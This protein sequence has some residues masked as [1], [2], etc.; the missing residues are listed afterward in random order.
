MAKRRCRYCGRWFIADPRVGDR[1]KACSRQC[2][3]LRKKENNH[4]F[5]KNNPGYWH[6]RYE[7]VKQWRQK[8]PGYQGQWRAKSR[9]Q[10]R[11][12]FEIQAERE[13]KASV[14]RGLMEVFFDE[15]QEKGV[16]HK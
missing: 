11:S 8:H 14:H 9:Q 3:R 16:R 5:S 7:Y 13:K 15:I 6:G 10:V 1:Q 2:Q 4:I 12:Q